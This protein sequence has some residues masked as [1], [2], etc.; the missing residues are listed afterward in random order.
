MRREEILNRLHADVLR[1]AEL[2]EVLRDGPIL[3]GDT[4]LRR[5]CVLQAGRA[6]RAAPGRPFLGPAR[7][8]APP[9]RPAPARPV[10]P[11]G[12]SRH[13]GRPAR[14]TPSASSAAT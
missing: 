6:I 7:W 2:F 14:R 11:A 10:S 3:L 9:R 13:T 1:R 5:L 12:A 4:R 8:P